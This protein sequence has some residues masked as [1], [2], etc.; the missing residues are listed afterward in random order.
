MSQVVWHKKIYTKERHHVRAKRFPCSSSWSSYHTIQDEIRNAGGSWVDREVVENGN[1]VTSR[2][3]G[4]LP[5]FIRT[6]IKY[7]SRTSV[8]LH[9]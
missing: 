2:Q 4:E 8:M 3:P 9:L 6:M 7:F 1:W 5:A